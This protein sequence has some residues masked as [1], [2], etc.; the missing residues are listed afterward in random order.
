MSRLSGAY[1]GRILNG[2]KPTDLP[3]AQPT[4]FAFVINLK[5][6][7][8][9]G[10]HPGNAV[11]HRRRGNSVKWCKSITCRRL[12]LLSLPFVLICAAKPIFAQSITS[13]QARIEAATRVLESNSK[14]KSLSPNFRQQLMEFVAGNMLFVLLHE[15]GHAA[16][17]EFD[18]PVLGK[19]EDA[20]DSF[21]ATRLIKIGTE[22]SD[23]VVVNTAKGWFMADLREKSS[24][25]RRD[26]PSRTCRSCGHHH[27]SRHAGNRRR[28]RAGRIFREG[29]RLQ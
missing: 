20:A 21:A 8:A 4:K 7:K 26:R 3:I 22:F 17:S 2:E 16:V 23:E 11:G 15:L 27:G 6:A 1:T 13:P 25:C 12:A 19:D 9:L 14:Y 28:D 10:L 24:P 29:G 5:T 18:I